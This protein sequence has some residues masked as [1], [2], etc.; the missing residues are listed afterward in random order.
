MIPREA[1]DRIEA[2]GRGVILFIPGSVDL[3]RDLAFHSGAALP[4]ART[5]QGEVLRE[6]GL[7]AQVIRDLGL[8]QIRILTN[9]PRRI[10]GLE[11]YGLEVVEQIVLREGDCARRPLATH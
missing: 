1:V 2:E 11:G 5:D 7:G 6:F 9:R 3:V 10:A 8:R 4:P